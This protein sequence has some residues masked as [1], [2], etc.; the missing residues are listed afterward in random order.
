MAREAQLL[1]RVRHPNV[2]AIL[3]VDVDASGTL[4]LVMEYVEGPTLRSL[5]SENPD[6][7]TCLDLLGQLAAGLAAVHEALVVHRDL[8]PANVLVEEIEE[9]GARRP[10]VR[11][12][13]FGVSHVVEAPE[14]ATASETQTLGLTRTDAQVGTPLYMAPEVL[15]GQQVGFAADVFA[16]GLIAF[17][18]LTGQKPRADGRPT[19]TAHAAL[20]ETRRDLLTAARPDLDGALVD[21][22]DRCCDADPGRRPTA[23]ALSEALRA[24]NEAG[25]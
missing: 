12:V 1:A 21:L 24:A 20:V 25:V 2:V 9:R 7:A 16:F 15:A 23:R 14:G 17:E 11:V 19:D 6:L 3:D 22:L 18:L 13:D 8:K 5:T 10:R 4:F